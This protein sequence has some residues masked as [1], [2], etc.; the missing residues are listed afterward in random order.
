MHLH[1]TSGALVDLQHHNLIGWNM[2]DLKCVCVCDK[3]MHMNGSDFKYMVNLTVNHIVVHPT[4]YPLVL[5]HNN[6]TTE[7]THCMHTTQ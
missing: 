6:I 3:T 2:T 5:I 1:A 7:C 4:K